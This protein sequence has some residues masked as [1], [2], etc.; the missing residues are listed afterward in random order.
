MD[1]LDERMIAAWQLASSD[2]GFRLIAP[3]AT[4][5]RAG[6]ELV[7]EGYLPDFGGPDGMAVVSFARRI[8]FDAIEPPMSI[9]GKESRKYIRKHVIAELRDWGWF[10][11]DEAPSWLAGR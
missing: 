10:G 2:L 4:K 8:K 1:S 9:L 11:P 5:D 3:F 7:L 6:N